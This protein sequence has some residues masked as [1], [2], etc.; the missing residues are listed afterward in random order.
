MKRIRKILKDFMEL[1]I[2]AKNILLKTLLAEWGIHLNLAVIPM[3]AMIL[4]LLIFQQFYDLTLNKIH[5]NQ[6][7][8]L[9]ITQ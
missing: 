3:I 7:K 2:F 4:G 6:L 9:K 1:A 8:I 5:E